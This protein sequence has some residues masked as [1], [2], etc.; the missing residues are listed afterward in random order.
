MLL[1]L[2]GGVITQAEETEG[3][4]EMTGNAKIAAVETDDFK[5]D[6]LQ[7]GNGDETLVI[8]PGLSVQSVM[9]SADAVVKAYQQLADHYTI[10]LFD[11]RKELPAEYSLQDMADDT[12]Q[13]IAAAGLDE[14]NLFGVSQGGM[15]AMGIAIEHPEL[16]KKLVLGST[17]SDITKE[18]YQLIDKWIQMAKEGRAED[19]YLSFGEMLYPEDVINQSKDLL[20]AAAKTVTKED[21]DRFIILA[22]SLRD[23][24]ITDELDQIACPVLLIGSKDDRVLGVE[25][26]QVIAE[27]LSGRPDFELY[28]YDGYGHAA[29]DTAPDYKERVLS[30]LEIH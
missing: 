4:S 21:L 27:H 1:L 28:L 2:F 18:T 12:A 16:V 7:F 20:K 19:L 8:L 17:S 11:R 24:D 15:I 5:M 13:A 3:E 29:Y 10:C 23:F 25:A 30:F 9:G 26:T 6:Y 14:V 22:Q